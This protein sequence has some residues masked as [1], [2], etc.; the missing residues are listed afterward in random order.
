M[1]LKNNKS[2]WA[3]LATLGVTAIAAGA[4]AF[5][6]IRDKRRQREEEEKADAENWK[7]VMCFHGRDKE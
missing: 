2:A 6:K 7:R 3:A 5:V 1:E 4:T